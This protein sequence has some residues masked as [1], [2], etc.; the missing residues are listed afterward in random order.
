MPA[1]LFVKYRTPSKVPYIYDL[2]TGEI[3][4]VDDLVYEIIDEFRILSDDELVRFYSHVDAGAVRNALGALHA[5]RERGILQDHEP[6]V[7]ARPD[8][9]YSQGVAQTADE[10][11][12]NNRGVLVLCLTEQCNLRCD[13]CPY[14]EHYPR[15]R[16]HAQQTMSLEVAERA[17]LEHLRQSAVDTPCIALYGGEPLLNWPLIQHIIP[18]A[19][20]HA[21]ALGKHRL[22]LAVTTNATLLT[23]EKIHYLVE[24]NVAV[25]I[26][27]D[28]PKDSHDRYRVFKDGTGSGKRVGSFDLVMRNIRRFVELYPKYRDR[29]VMVTIAPP[30]DFPASK[31]L[32]D[33]LWPNFPISRVNFVTEEYGSTFKSEGVR[34]PKQ[35]GCIPESSCGTQGGG[36][37]TTKAAPAPGNSLLPILSDSG[38]CCSA[39]AGQSPERQQI[40]DYA[41]RT[42]ARREGDRTAASLTPEASDDR[43]VSGLIREYID[44]K[45][46]FG[47]DHGFR[48]SFTDSMFRD[49]MIHI[50]ERQ[51]TTGKPPHMFN[52]KCYPGA[53]RLF[54]DI[55]GRYY[56]CEKC[57]SSE[58]TNLGDV[59][60]GFDPRRS[61]LMME[62]YRHIADCGNCIAQKHCSNCY[63]GLQKKHDSDGLVGEAYD[64]SCQQT[65]ATTASNLR[66]YTEI[67][68]KN[69]DAF[70]F[71]SASRIVEL[72]DHKDLRE[73]VTEQVDYEPGK[74][75]VAPLSLMKAI[76]NEATQQVGVEELIW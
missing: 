17:I 39:N 29:G 30:Y 35:T 67:M 8:A 33:E 3:L 50:H 20:K 38:Q 73:V 55:H 53:V 47:S 75:T 46:T 58:V 28:G 36:C 64:F 68:E 45:V 26:S 5:I 71:P 57:E 14:G 59:W 76:E 54:C 11:F 34:R 40:S 74:L 25:S 49:T 7:P 21:A 62:R 37:C 51:V 19:E 48:K 43:Q 61:E 12:G 15:F 10:Y 16:E 6:V 4:K 42:H 66:T 32:I 13:Y 70:D 56:V 65:R 23:D 31:E 63:R 44:G 27:L 69:P 22:I 60:S 9:F 52:Y 72:T 2:G 1:P 24:H 41:E 18:F